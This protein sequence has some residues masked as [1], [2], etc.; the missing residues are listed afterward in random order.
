MLTSCGASVCSYLSSNGRGGNTIEWG[1]DTVRRTSILELLVI[2]GCNDDEVRL[3]WLLL[4]NTILGTVLSCLRVENRA[5][6]SV[7]FLR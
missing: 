3:V 4:S 1:F 5:L 7:Q 2:C 6:L